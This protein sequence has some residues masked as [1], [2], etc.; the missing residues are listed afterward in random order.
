MNTNPN[1]ED[2][3]ARFIAISTNNVNEHKV[4]EVYH[5]PLGIWGLDIGYTINF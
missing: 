2:L 1:P 3:N 4:A 5:T